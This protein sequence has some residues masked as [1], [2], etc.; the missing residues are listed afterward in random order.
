[1]ELGKEESRLRKQ[2]PMDNHHGHDG[3]M[4]SQKKQK[5]ESTTS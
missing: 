4:E 2:K 5:I 1:M 3:G